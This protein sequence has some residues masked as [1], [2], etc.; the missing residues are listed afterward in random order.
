MNYLLRNIDPDIWRRFKA[1]T[2]L[3]RTTMSA[4]LLQAIASY[5]DATPRQPM[6]AKTVSEASHD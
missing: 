1:R 5:A 6:H 3:E 4:V 2:I